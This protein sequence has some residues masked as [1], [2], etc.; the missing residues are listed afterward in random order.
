VIK[1]ETGDLNWLVG[2][3]EGEGSFI[4]NASVRDGGVGF[5]PYLR[6]VLSEKDRETVFLIKKMLGFGRIE[7]KSNEIWKRK[8]MNNVQ[9]QYSYTI[10]GVIAAQKFIENFGENL[11]RTSKKED[12]VLW[13]KAIEIIKNY[14]HL[15]YE[16]FVNI[17]EIRDKMN[18]KQKRKNYRDKNW[19]LNYIRKNENFF[20]EKNIQKRK[21]TSISIRRLNNIELSMRS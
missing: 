8:G 15:T 19:F 9:N 10:S 2:L 13:K 20:S 6:I 16:G 1:L 14:R 3:I 11:F 17:C 7:F 12:F 21:R 4:I 5:C 18:L